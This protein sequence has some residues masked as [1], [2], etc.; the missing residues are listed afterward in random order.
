MFVWNLLIKHKTSIGLTLLLLGSCAHNRQPED[1]ESVRESIKVDSSEMWKITW[2]NN[3]AV[4]PGNGT[5]IGTDKHVMIVTPTKI[6]EWNEG[7]SASE[8]YKNE[9][10]IRALFKEHREAVSAILPQL[11]SLSGVYSLGPEAND[12]GSYFETCTVEFKGET[13][14]FDLIQGSGAQPMPSALKELI[15]LLHRKI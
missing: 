1:R 8:S 3:D 6:R 4:D 10:T 14:H 5:I 7:E 13:L 11:Q 9:A 15:L 2:S 12:E